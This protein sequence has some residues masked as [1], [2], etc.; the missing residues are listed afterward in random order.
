MIEQMA[1]V[2]LGTLEIFRNLI[3][4]NIK[5]QAQRNWNVEVDAQ[6]VGFDRSAEAHSSFNISKALDETAARR[7]RRFTNGD[8]KQPIENIS[9]N[10]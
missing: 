8:V 5:K 7:Y 6:N 3:A 10:P 2:V 1:I 4:A 9:T